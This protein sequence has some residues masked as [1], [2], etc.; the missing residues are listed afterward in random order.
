MTDHSKVDTDRWR[1]D[2]GEKPL[3]SNKKK[4]ATPSTA[5]RSRHPASKGVYR[6]K[7]EVVA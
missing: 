4:R 3:A 5:K 7:R 1:T 2:S 6:W